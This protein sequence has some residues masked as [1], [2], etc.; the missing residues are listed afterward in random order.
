MKA[1][2]N[3]FFLDAESA[4]ALQLLLRK[5]VLGAGVFQTGDCRKT[6]EELAAKGVEFKSPPQERFY[7]T[8][9]AFKDNCGNWFSLMQPKS[10]QQ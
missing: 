6:Y 3:P 2:I 5:G 1:A 8:E 10:L 7:G 9:A 4:A